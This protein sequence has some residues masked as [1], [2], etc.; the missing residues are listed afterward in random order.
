MQIQFLIL[1]LGPKTL[2]RVGGRVCAR[3]GVHVCLM[4]PLNQLTL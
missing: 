1:K 4:L 2:T 3:A